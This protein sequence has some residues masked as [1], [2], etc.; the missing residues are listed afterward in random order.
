MPLKIT[1]GH[2]TTRRHIQHG[3]TFGVLRE[4]CERFLSV[5][6]HFKHHPCQED[7]YNCSFQ[8][9]EQWKKQPVGR[10]EDPLEWG[11]AL[12]GSPEVWAALSEPDHPRTNFKLRSKAPGPHM[13]CYGSTSAMSTSGANSSSDNRNSSGFG[14]EERYRRKRTSAAAK[15]P[16]QYPPLAQR[17]LLGASSAS[18]TV[19]GL[20]GH[21]AALQPVALTGGASPQ[22]APKM[23]RRRGAPLPLWVAQGQANRQSAYFRGPSPAFLAHTRVVCYSRLATDLWDVIDEAAPGCLEGMDAK[24]SIGIEGAPSEQ[25]R[26]VHLERRNVDKTHGGGPAKRMAATP[27]VCDVAHRLYPEDLELWEQYCT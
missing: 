6:Q 21:L 11:H 22:S 17:A 27:E 13:R 10:F 3:L 25:R 9:V 2:D 12:L 26:A 4:P 1:A 20:R 16:S 7:E 14:E 5:H 24:T 23:R 8:P 18:G 15:R 19:S